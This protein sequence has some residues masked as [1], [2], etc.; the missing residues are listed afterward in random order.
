MLDTC[1]VQ[2][3]PL[4]TFLDSHSALE[5][6]SSNAVYLADSG[7]AGFRY[8]HKL[9]DST[10]ENARPAD[11]FVGRRPDEPVLEGGLGIIVLS[12]SLTWSIMGV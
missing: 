2:P 11:Q 1:D 9:G 3:V 10:H 8:C 5:S 4:S 7:G 12:V 6:L